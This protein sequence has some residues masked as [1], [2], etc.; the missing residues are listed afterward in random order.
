M[1]SPCRLKG[2]IPTL[3]EALDLPVKPGRHIFLNRNETPICRRFEIHHLDLKL[4]DL[5]NQ[6]SWVQEQGGCLGV[7]ELPSLVRG[8]LEGGIIDGPHVLVDLGPKL[9]LL[10]QLRILRVAAVQPAIF[11]ESATLAYG[12]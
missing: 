4:P 10:H 1:L 6:V 12:R 2:L 8:G 5:G 9:K 11:N 3:L 7:R